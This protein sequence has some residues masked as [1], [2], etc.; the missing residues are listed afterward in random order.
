MQPE[1]SNPQKSV[2]LALDLLALLKPTPE[3][4]FLL[5]G[6]AIGGGTGIA[7]VLFHYLIQLV[8]RLLLE[9]L[10]GVL[11]SIGTWTLICA[12]CLGGLTVG[13]M[14]WRL[15]DFGVSL[16]SLIAASHI[17]RNLS[18]LKAIARAIAAAVSLGS[19]ASLGQ[20]G[21]SVEIGS[22]IG[23]CIGQHLKV[24]QER[25]RLLMGAGAAAGLSAGFNAPIAGVFFALEVVLGTT[26]ATS[27]VSVILLSAVVAALISQIG[28]GGQPAFILPRYELKGFLELPFYLGLGLF[29]CLVSITYTQTIQIAKKLFQGQL[30]SLQWVGQLPPFVQPAIGGLGLGVVALF[31]PQT[32]GIGYET[33]DV[34]LRDVQMPLSL[35]LTLLVV[36]LGLTAL[37]LGSGFV[38]GLFGPAMFLGASLGAAYGKIL[39]Y[40]PFASLLPISAPPAYAMVGMAA[41]LAASVRAPLTA[42]LLLF[43]LTRDYRIILP[44]M[45]AVGLSVWLIE[46]LKPIAP[47]IPT[48]QPTELKQEPNRDELVMQQLRVAEAMQPEYLAIDAELSVVTALALLTE[49]QSRCALVFEQSTAALAGIVTLQDIERGIGLWQ[50][51][52][53]IAP[54]SHEQDAANETG[55]EA[56]TVVLP[57]TVGQI[58]T[59]E[60]L[61]AY[62]DESLAEAKTRMAGRG[63]RQL[64]V[65]DRDNVRQILG[66]LDQDH[67][68]LV[69]S[70]ATAQK[71]LEPHLASLRS[72]TEQDLDRPASTPGSEPQFQ[73]SIS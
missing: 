71:A 42:I 26:F 22:H 11:A 50:A 35:L 12:P 45:A 62:P 67:I 28:L 8:Q 1:S 32:L 54:T 25:L 58:C 14:R 69:C 70:L 51:A 18:P 63:L 30:T 43:E 13:L 53:A 31:L 61:Y 6:I 9:D 64:P 29:A 48:A 59:R 27:A 16:S 4:L 24:S 72:L 36:K 60:V 21:P 33:I 7:I 65:V 55:A 47:D 39:P 73:Q 3:T 23:I 19:G 10:M 15:Q 57:T 68:A 56:V 40:L 5:L 2:N 41:V 52:I 34:I 38:G 37:S 17:P 46:Y 20:E 66:V 49:H 44:L